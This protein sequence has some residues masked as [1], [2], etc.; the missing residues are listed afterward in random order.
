MKSNQKNTK[1]MEKD[2]Q[3]KLFRTSTA[4]LFDPVDCLEVEKVA[5]P[6]K[7]L[8]KHTPYFSAEAPE[9]FRI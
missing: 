6:V 2:A 5:A 4:N 9:D 3:L 1:N 7:T 8:Y